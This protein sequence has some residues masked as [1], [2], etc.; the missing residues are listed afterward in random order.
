MEKNQEM[1]FT[2]MFSKWNSWGSPVGLGI[3]I[4]SIAL[5][6]LL[7][8]AAVNQFADPGY[9]GNL[10]LKESPKKD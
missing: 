3:L 1:K 4:V 6:V 9:K 8:A 10:M 7:V 2:K 5:S